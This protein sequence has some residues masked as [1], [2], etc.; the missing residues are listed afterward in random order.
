MA[1]ELRENFVC[2]DFQQK[3]KSFLSGRGGV[4][5][6]WACYRAKGKTE[7]ASICGTRWTGNC[8]AVPGLC[9]SSLGAQLPQ[10]PATVIDAQFRQPNSRPFSYSPASPLPP[11]APLSVYPFHA[12]VFF[13]IR[14]E[15]QRV[16]HRPSAASVTRRRV[17]LAP[18]LLPSFS[19]PFVS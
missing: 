8:A 2:A 4:E 12:L 14:F 3:W 18:T 9:R 17:V 13:F 19:P 1:E 16:H 15:R 10:T 11:V 7:H 5:K 6:K